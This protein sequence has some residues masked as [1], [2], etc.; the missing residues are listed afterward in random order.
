MNPRVSIITVVYNGVQFIEK[1][2]QSVLSQTYPNIEYIII[3]GGSSDGTL[4]IIKKY[5]HKLSKCVSE[6]DAGIFDAMN[7]GI[8][9]ASGELIG[10]LNAD[11]WYEIDAIQNIVNAFN[12]FPEADVLH[13]LLSFRDQ[14][15]NIQYVEGHTLDYFSKGIEHP[16]C[17]IKKAAYQTH[18]TFNS[19][20]KSA[21]DYE[22]L[23]RFK[24]QGLN[25]VFVDKILANFR[26]GGSSTSLKGAIE[27][28]NLNYQY[29]SISQIK[30][31]ALLGYWRLKSK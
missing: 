27:T 31:L 21:G 8:G 24:E 12:K 29:G 2:I 25:F 23:L 20:Y 16:T 28:I 14:N 5:Q 19:K 17:F 4:D 18:G 13:G 11:D 26:S 3:D 10:I 9:M 1:A 7:K 30:R 6:K 22:L 15:E